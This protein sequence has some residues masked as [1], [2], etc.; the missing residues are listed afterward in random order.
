MKWSLYSVDRRLAARVGAIY[1]VNHVSQRTVTHID[2]QA[3]PP[4]SF[5]ERGEIFRARRYGERCYVAMTFLQAARAATYG[6]EGA[7][8]FTIF[9]NTL[10][11]CV[12]LADHVPA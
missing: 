5:D 11:P 9:P 2:F 3:V 6:W 1:G 12:G 10:P 7:S 4:F 8:F